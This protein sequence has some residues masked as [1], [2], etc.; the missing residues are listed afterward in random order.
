MIAY[1]ADCVDRDA[2]TV[3]VWDLTTDQQFEAPLQTVQVPW[4]KTANTSQRADAAD[5][6]QLRLGEKVNVLRI[7]L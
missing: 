2:G 3:L 5:D 4:T 6:L 1:F 7:L